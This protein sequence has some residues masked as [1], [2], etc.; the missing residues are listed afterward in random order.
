MC[1]MA[2]TTNVARAV[3]KSV[4]RRRTNVSSEC[5]SPKK[6]KT[7]AIRNQKTLDS[8]MGDRGRHF[9]LPCAEKCRARACTAQGEPRPSG[10]GFR[11]NPALTGGAQGRHARIDGMPSIQG[12]KAIVTGAT[13]GIGRAIAKMLLEEG[14]EVAI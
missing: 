7:A 13:R 3:R 6:Y 12:K 11:A 1:R 8:C 4:V 14:A 10:R 2:A 9:I 5:I